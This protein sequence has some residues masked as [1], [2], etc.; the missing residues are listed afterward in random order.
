MFVHIL[1][2]RG[3]KNYTSSMPKWGIILLADTWS[4]W[5]TSLYWCEKH[6]LEKTYLSSR[7]RRNPRKEYADGFT[8]GSLMWVQSICSEKTT[9]EENGIIW[10]WACCHRQHTLIWVTAKH[11]CDISGTWG[12]PLEPTISA[13]FWRNFGKS[14]WKIWNLET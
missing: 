1:L 9:A 13:S 8:Q 7:R 11:R 12:T 2:Q 10:D 3:I 6:F 5:H 14:S 4:Y